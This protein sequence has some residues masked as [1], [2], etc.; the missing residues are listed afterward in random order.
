VRP[1]RSD[2]VVTDERRTRS[3]R[4]SLPR[5]ETRNRARGGGGGPHHLQPLVGIEALVKKYRDFRPQVEPVSFPADDGALKGAIDDQ[6]THKGM[7]SRS[8]LRVLARA[9]QVAYVW[10]AF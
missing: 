2:W 4:L 8:I 3:A 1:V 9:P 6:T 5:Q 10:I 7:I